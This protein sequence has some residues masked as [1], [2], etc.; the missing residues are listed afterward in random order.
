[1]GTAWLPA[2]T[3]AIFLEYEAVLSRATIRR[4]TGLSARDVAIT[5]DYIANVAEQCMTYFTWRPNL[6]DEGD[7]MFVECAVAAS[8]EYLITG[9]RRH[10][11]RW[12]LGPFG[13]DLVTPAQFAE[14]LSKED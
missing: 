2:I 7:N 6:P 8:A 10:F 5:L 4:L 12:E 9:N 14:F 11:E 3:P 1:M 13:F